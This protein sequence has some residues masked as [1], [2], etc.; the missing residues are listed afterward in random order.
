MP[1]MFLFLFYNWNAALNFYYLLFNVLTSIQ[2]KFIHKPETETEVQTAE[3]PSG[4][5]VNDKA[6]KVKIDKKSKM[7]K[8]K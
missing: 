7:Y 5:S 3:G 2:Q 4:F 8:K 6:N 1:V